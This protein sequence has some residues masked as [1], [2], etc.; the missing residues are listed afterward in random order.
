MGV[1]MLFGKGGRKAEEVK[2]EELEGYLD[3]LFDAKLGSLESRAS[4][5]VKELSRARLQFANSSKSFGELNAEPE[6][7]YFFI[8]NINFIKGQK[9]SYTKTLNRLIEEWTVERDDKS[10]TNRYAKYAQILSDADSFI[11]EVL[12]ANNNFKK[13]LQS[14]PD[15]L[16]KFKSSFSLVERYTESLKNE[17]SKNESLFTEYRIVSNGIHEMKKARERCISI[18]ESI[19]TLGERASIKKEETNPEAEIQSRITEREAELSRLNGEISLLSAKISSAATAI[20]RPARKFDHISGRKMQ[21]HKFLENPLN[22]MNS[23]ED[24]REFI[25]MLKLLK[26]S[27][28]EGKIEA[29]NPQKLLEYVNELI[30]MDIYEKSQKITGLQHERSNATR[31][32]AELRVQSEKYSVSRSNS[33]NAI[34]NI[35]SLKAEAANCTA[36]ANDAKAALEAL[37]LRYY[38]K[39]ISIIG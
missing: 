17:I 27:I 34:K 3:S 6:L 39:S 11:K 25:S 31:D 14:Y 35:E 38:S 37:F 23:E 5:I 15:H 2:A 29:K 13:V 12:K 33:E 28:E 16:D 7:E 32:I 1:I 20:E 22:S 24:H 36:K 18:D 9:L 21:L 30:D 19:R 4:N 8:D 26:G 10:V